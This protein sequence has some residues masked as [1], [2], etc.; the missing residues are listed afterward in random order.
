M[1]QLDHRTLED[2]RMELHERA[3]AREA[4][5]VTGTRED[6]RHV[7]AFVRL[8]SNGIGRTGI[9]LVHACGGDIHVALECLL[10]EDAERPSLHR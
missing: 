1:G 4:V 10:A 5:L 8:R 6:G 3:L 7:A 2:L 9:V